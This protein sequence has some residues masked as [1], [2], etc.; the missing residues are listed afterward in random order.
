M[1]CPMMSRKEIGYEGEFY[2]CQK[3]LCAWWIRENEM[4]A[5]F[6]FGYFCSVKGMMDSYFPFDVVYP[7][8]DKK[9]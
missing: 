8:G 6:M 4:C 5:I 2:N 7:E 3:A 1:V 9:E